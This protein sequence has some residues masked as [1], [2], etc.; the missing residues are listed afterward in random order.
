MKDL[1]IN[2]MKDVQ[3]LYFTTWLTH[4]E[5]INKWR[6]ITCSWARSQEVNSLQIDIQIQNN[7]KQKAGCSV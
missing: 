6:E 5:D 7:P 1:E 4:F 3:D 2:M